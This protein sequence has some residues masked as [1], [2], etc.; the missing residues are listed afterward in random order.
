M[1]SGNTEILYWR[2]NK[3]WYKYDET[4]DMYE[5]TD[6][7]TDRAKSSFELWKEFNHLK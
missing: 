6:K 4:K 1:M 7:A 3:E 2:S 5:L